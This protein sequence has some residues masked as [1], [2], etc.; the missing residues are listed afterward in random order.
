MSVRCQPPSAAAQA[1]YRRIPKQHT[2][3]EAP[4][5]LAGEMS[6]GILDGSAPAPPT[7]LSEVGTFTRE[8]SVI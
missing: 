2:G 4:S 6:A 7:G 8:S 3:P 5:A 1:L